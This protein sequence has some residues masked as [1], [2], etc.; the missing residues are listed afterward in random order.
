[1]AVDVRLM[2]SQWPRAGHEFPPVT[3]TGRHNASIFASGGYPGIRPDGSY[4]VESGEVAGLDRAEDGGWVHRQTGD[5]I[6]LSDRHLVLAYG[7]N[8]DPAKLTKNLGGSAV[9]AL[10]C[11][12]HDHA[13]VWCAG[14]S[15][16]GS[17]VV[18]IH[19]EPG[20]LELHHVLAVT[21]DQLAAID[22][23][24]GH[25]GTYERRALVGRVTVDG[26][27]ASATSPT[28]G[29][30]A[31]TVERSVLVYVGARAERQ[32]LRHDGRMWYL[33]DHTHDD[34]DPLVAR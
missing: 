27:G 9:Y 22:E 32:P 21:A 20:R 14:R 8:G 31:E 3:W 25:P 28:D 15:G 4:V 18:T 10:R 11:L 26:D 19:P 29:T 33:T 23:W 13:T 24:E 16:D 1:M 2:T 5:R 30:A 12:V 34:V 17:V 7:S 6:D